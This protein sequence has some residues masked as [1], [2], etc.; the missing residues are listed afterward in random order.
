MTLTNWIHAAVTVGAV[1]QTLFI[2][3]FGSAMKL[4][5]P[6]FVGR[7]LFTKGLVLAVILDLGVVAIWVDVPLVVFVVLYW[8]IAAAI[9]QQFA[10]LVVM[11]RQ[12]RR[13]LNVATRAARAARRD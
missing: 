1:G 6:D 4:W 12:R 5:L 10:A 9:W 13:R 3:L 11:R 2:M 8:L 7:A